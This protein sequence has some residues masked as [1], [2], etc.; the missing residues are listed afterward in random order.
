VKELTWQEAALAWAQGKRVE[1]AVIGGDEWLP[2]DPVGSAGRESFS[3]YSPGIFGECS[4]SYKFRLAPEPPAKKFRPWTPEEV[5]VGAQVRYKNNRLSIRMLIVS[6]VPP[7]FLGEK[8][9][10]TLG[11]LFCLMEHSIDGGKTWSVCGIEEAE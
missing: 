10:W 5:P 7:C 2:I 9:F 11:D 4:H 6:N 1:A 8:S 3:S